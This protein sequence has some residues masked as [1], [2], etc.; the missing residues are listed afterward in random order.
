MSKILDLSSGNNWLST[1]QTRRRLLTGIAAGISTAAILPVR[2][3][4]AQSGVKIGI[5]LAKQGP[6]TQQASDM[7]KGI[8]IALD[9]LG[10]QVGGQ[11]V[12]LIWLDESNPQVSVQNFTK[13][14]D[15]ENVIAVLG[16]TSSANTLA[17]GSTAL[18]RKVPFI[19]IN[20]SA[21]EVTGKDC[22]PFLFRMPGSLPAYA[23][24]MAPHMAEAGKRWHIL[25]AS[26]AFGE[27]IINTFTALAKTVGATIVGVDSAPVATTDFSSFVLKARATN[28]DVVISGAPNVHP[29]LKQVYDLGLGDTMTVAGPAVSDTDLWS[30]EPGALQGI[31]GKTWYFNDPN[32][33]PEEKAFTKKFLESEGQ[34]PSDRVFYGWLSMHLLAASIDHAK[35]VDRLAIT[36]ALTSMKL[37]DGGLPFGFRDWDHQLT[38]RL[39]VG[40]AQQNE[41]DKWD[42]LTIVSPKPT[43]VEEVERVYGEKAESECK[44]AS[45]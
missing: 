32:N 35:S 8:Q 30:A 36:K 20:A 28:P 25:S 45:I 26:Y 15:S 18:Q 23:R 37:S 41:K 7:Q 29:I 21:R 6:F 39:V 12:E 3:A 11:P 31:Y 19:S 27:D 14:A 9:E 17:M 16:G 10:G 33:A 4:F 40:K 22:N 44:M 13:L 34:P 1:D 5:L 43:T 2:K 24:V 38:R 42:V